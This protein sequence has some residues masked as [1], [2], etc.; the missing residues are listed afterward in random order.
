[1]LGKIIYKIILTITLTFNSL[2]FSATWK[3]FFYMD[4]SDDLSDMAIKNITDMV[5]TKPQDN[6][7]LLIQ[8]HAY[9]KAGLRYKVTENSLTFLE[10]VEL[11]GDPK[12]DLIDASSWAFKDNKHDYTMLILSNHGWGILDPKYNSDTDQW[13]AN[14]EPISN[15]CSLKYLEEHKRHKGFMFNK[16]TKNYLNNQELIGSLNYIKNNL[17]NG[18]NLDILAFDTCMGSMLEVAYQ[19][20]P[21]VNY[22]VGNQSCSLP[23]GF[24]YQGVI[25]A[26]NKKN[27]PIN[28]IKDMVQAFDNYYKKNDSSG[29]YT[30]AGLDLSY[31]NE[32]KETLDAIVTQ[33]LDI[34]EI[35]QILIKAQNNTPRFCMWPMYTDPIAFCK[36]IEEQLDPIQGPSKIKAL[37]QTLEKLYIIVEQAVVARCGGHTTQNLAYGF[38]IYLPMNIIDSS[39]YNTSFAKE[40][41]WLDLLKH[42]LQNQKIETPI[43]FTPQNI[44]IN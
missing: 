14:A 21:F 37:K 30:H 25:S 43:N 28:T 18:K 15:Y 34:P 29:V 40:S 26:L 13:Q 24:D 31:T 32:I 4:S 39:Y 10:E 7:E 16:T 23:D 20:S 44:K 33:L 2:L 38:S 5:R 6:I 41:K 1:M 9:H 17:L 27:N 22:L 35:N 3:V 11:K 19:I 42:L 8:L 36:I 12:Q